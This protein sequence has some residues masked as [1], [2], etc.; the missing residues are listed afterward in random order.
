MGS[1]V[2][3]NEDADVSV[4]VDEG[5][6]SDD[7]GGRCERGRLFRVLGLVGKVQGRGQGWVNAL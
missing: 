1:V 6:Y 2:W 3:L 7:D 5:E 4:G